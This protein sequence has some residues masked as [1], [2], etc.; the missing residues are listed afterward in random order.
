MTEI[1]ARDRRG[2]RVRAWTSP[3]NTYAYP[4]WFNSLSAFIPPWAHDGGDE[5][6]LARLKD[7]PRARASAG[8]ADARRRAGTTS[9]RRFPGPR[10]S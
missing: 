1:V 5:Q 7:P 9:G 2:A 10:P 3:P 8:D 4:A 6:L